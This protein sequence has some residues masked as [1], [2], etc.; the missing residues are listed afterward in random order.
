MRGVPVISP[1]VDGKAARKCRRLSKFAH[2]RLS[3]DAI[4]HV[5]M[6]QLAETS[7]LVGMELLP[8]QIPPVGLCAEGSFSN[9]EKIK[10]IVLVGAWR[11]ELQTSCAQARRIVSWKPFPFNPN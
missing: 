7:E 10:R 6:R 1:T 9:T 5:C 8:A 3:A 2:G 11:F 4:E